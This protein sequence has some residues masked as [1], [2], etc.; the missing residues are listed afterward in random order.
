MDIARKS[1]AIIMAAGKG[2][3]MKDPAQA[4]VLYEIHGKPMIHYVVELASRLS[5]DRV[6]VVVGHQREAVMEYLRTAHPFVECVVQAEQL[7]TGH[8]VMQAKNALEGFNGHVT[9]LS[10]DVPMLRKNTMDAL[11]AHHLA[12]QAMA[13]ILTAEMPDPTGYGRILRRSDGSVSRIVEQRDATPEESAVTEINSGIY[14]F[15]KRHLFEALEL[16]KPDNVQHEYYL[17]DVFEH[18]ARRGWKV[19]ARK[20]PNVDEIRG[21]N[22][23]AQLEEARS[24]MQSRRDAG[25]GSGGA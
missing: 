22:T 1:A 9:V 10:G 6:I 25:I 18:F 5:M 3:R 11:I 2:T 15:E 8:A 4:K 7:G 16:I 20:S 14:V 23:Y 21:I 17:T 12:T 24:L 19:S 13:T